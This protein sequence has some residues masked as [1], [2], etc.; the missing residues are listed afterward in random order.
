MKKKARK[1]ENLR[2]KREKVRKPKC[3]KKRKNENIH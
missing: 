3:E 1:K 2:K